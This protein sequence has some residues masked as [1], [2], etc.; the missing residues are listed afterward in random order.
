MTISIIG[1]VIGIAVAAVCIYY[2]IKEK[3]DKESR[4]IYGIAG[5]AGAAIFAAMT[6][7]LILELR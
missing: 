5:A 3:N 7:K 2:F 6:I 4:R 1:M